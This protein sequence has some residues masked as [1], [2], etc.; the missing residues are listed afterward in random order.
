[1]ARARAASQGRTYV[2]DDDIKSVA[3]PVISHRMILR[4]EAVLQGTEASAVVADVLRA[5]PV[6]YDRV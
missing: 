3:A 4:P 1:V 2:T 5:V 6:P